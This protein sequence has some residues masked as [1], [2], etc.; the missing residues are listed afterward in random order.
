MGVF[1]LPV[2]VRGDHKVVPK[3]DQKAALAGKY[4]PAEPA[5][6]IA[7]GQTNFRMPEP[8]LGEERAGGMVW[9]HRACSAPLICLPMRVRTRLADA[10]LSLLHFMVQVKVGI[11]SPALRRSRDTQPES[12]R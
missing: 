6:D 12:Y 7:L 8:L 9:R 11:G 5:D 3:P 2:R 4:R 10:N 1:S